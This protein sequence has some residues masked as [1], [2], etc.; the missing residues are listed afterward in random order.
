M[1]RQWRWCLSSAAHSHSPR[2]LASPCTCCTSLGTYVQDKPCAEAMCRQV[3]GRKC[4]GI[5]C[6]NIACIRGV[7]GVSCVRMLN[8]TR[9]C[10]SSEATTTR[11]M[12]G[13]PA[14]W[15]LTRSLHALKPHLTAM[16]VN[17]ARSILSWKGTSHCHGCVRGAHH[18]HG[19]CT[20]CRSA[21]GR[22]WQMRLR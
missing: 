15:Q 14:L 3:H 9:L 17:Q 16:L 21:T 19:L 20:T 18:A 22:W 4:S 2:L 5:T 13:S 6:S 10:T 8:R 7:N 11:R 1:A 12:G